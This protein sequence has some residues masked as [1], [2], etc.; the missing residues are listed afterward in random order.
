M[1][2]TIQTPDTVNPFKVLWDAGY[3]RLIPVVPPDAEVSKGGAL[4]RRMEAGEDPRGK[5]PGIRKPDG[6]WRGFDFTRMEAQETDLDTWG[7]WGA[8]VGI[9]TGDGLIAVDIDTTDRRAATKL[10]ELAAQHLGP[11]KVRF[12]QKPKCL[13]LYDAPKD[14]SYQWVSF[15]TETEDKAR[16]EILCEGRQFVAHGVHPKTKEPYTW[17]HGV[18]RRAQLAEITAEHLDGFMAA[19]ESTMA[20]AKRSGAHTAEDRDQDELKA[21]SWDAFR[22]AVE[23]VPNSSHLFPSRDSYVTMAYAIKAAAPDGYETPARDLF[24]D[25]CDRWEEGENNTVQAMGDFD[26]AKPPFKVGFDF[27]RAHAFGLFLEPIERDDIDD[28]FAATDE[29]RP[30]TQKGY[31]LL[32]IDD[33]FALPPPKFLIDRHLPDTGL[34]ILFGDPGCGKSFVALDQALHIAYGLPSWHGDRIDLADGERGGVLYI[35]GEGASGFRA[36]VK[37]WQAKNLTQE[38]A[39][40]KP[41]IHFLFEPINFMKP[42]D[43]HRLLEAVHNT[44]IQKLAFIVVDTVS[45]SIPGADENL[46]KDMTLFVSACD[47]LKHSTG[48]F[49][50]G[51][52]H[53]GK[54]GT[55]RGSS[56]FGGQA[57]AIFRMQRK[58][59][60]SIAALSCEKQ[61]DAP[62]GWHNH[63]RMDTITTAEG[64]QSLVIERTESDQVEE[65]T[66][67]PQMRSAILRA[68]QEAWDDGRPW[69]QHPQAKDRYAPKIISTQFDVSASTAG[70]WIAIWKDDEGLIEDQEASARNKYRGLCLT[71]EGLDTLSGGSGVEGGVFG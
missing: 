41:N 35:A 59:G 57:D 19:A 24:I 26:R 71:A 43:I 11:A 40:I 16:V 14:I 8:S 58:K 66:A 42:E 64:T 22:E 67:D 6:S 56:V 10:Y 44:G 52:H 39:H 31:R 53:T 62:D 46:Q 70:Q 51:V 49:V 61:K 33:V 50:L 38:H 48:A 2:S 32:S 4:H 37:A 1:M 17:T 12:G 3:H 23:A 65:A 34:G 21:P 9:K 29:A 69:S 63:Y 45:R 54:T 20:N 60:S 27:V 25:W 47:A 68:L 30:Q 15:S 7:R 28:M 36:R 13:L 55:M 5:V 18:P